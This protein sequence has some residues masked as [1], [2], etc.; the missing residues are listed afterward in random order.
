MDEQN[1]KDAQAWGRKKMAAFMI[2]LPIA[3]S[4]V[5]GLMFGAVLHSNGGFL[6]NWLLWSTGMFVLFGGG[7]T[8]GGI[9]TL[10]LPESVSDSFCSKAGY[11]L[12]Y[13][14]LGGAY[15]IG[16]LFDRGLT[17]DTVAL[18]FGICA[19]VCALLYYKGK[20]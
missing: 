7:G 14:T 15:V 1:K 19:L 9:L 3:V 13:G 17:A 16:G 4:G 5:V 20:K 18:S 11:G 12:Y 6:S 10:I 8:L 2:F